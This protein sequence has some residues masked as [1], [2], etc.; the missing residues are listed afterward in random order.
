MR[1][2][3]ESLI[4]TIAGDVTGVVVMAALAAGD[5]HFQRRDPLQRD[6]LTPRLQ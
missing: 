6:L 4:I 3:G 2:V 5:V 1:D